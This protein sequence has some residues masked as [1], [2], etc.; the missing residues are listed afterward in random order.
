VLLAVRTGHQRAGRATDL[1]QAVVGVTPAFQGL[2]FQG[3][4]QALAVA[5]D[6]QRLAGEDLDL[7]VVFLR[8]LGQVDNLAYEAVLG[9]GIGRDIFELGRVG[10]GG[11]G[12]EQ[13]RGGEGE[14]YLR[15]EASLQK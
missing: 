6:A 5:V 11:G 15:H 14:T 13:Q 7:E 1:V 9:L 8:L 3:A 12:A 2:L 10:Q 4:A